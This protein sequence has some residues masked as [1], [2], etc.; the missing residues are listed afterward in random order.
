MPSEWNPEGYKN[1]QN[2]NESLSHSDRKKISIK[3]EQ[4]FE[5]S[6]ITALELMAAEAG[7]SV[8]PLMI[9]RLKQA[10]KLDAESLVGKS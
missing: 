8:D 10:Q 5:P 2:T 4:L 7:E 9:H 6:E 1:T 3:S